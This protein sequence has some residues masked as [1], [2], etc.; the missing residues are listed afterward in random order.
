[1][2][3]K[4]TPYTQN[5]TPKDNYLIQEHLE[6]KKKERE[7]H[8]IDHQN[9]GHFHDL[10][11]NFFND[12]I[13]FKLDYDKEYLELIQ[14]QK[15]EVFYESNLSVKVKSVKTYSKSFKFILI[16][17]KRSDEHEVAIKCNYGTFKEVRK[18]LIIDLMKIVK[19][20]EIENTSTRTLP[21]REIWD[22]V[23]DTTI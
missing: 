22:W 15:S 21:K 12:V 19:D 11:N 2:S 1:M 3:R 13:G 23:E 16:I 7:Q 18:S 10:V 20:F 4:L 6:R 17:S 5:Y 8:L 9:E 14:Q